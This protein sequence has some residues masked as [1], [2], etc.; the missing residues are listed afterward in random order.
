MLQHFMVTI[1]YVPFVNS[2]REEHLNHFCSK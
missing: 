1:L 2:S